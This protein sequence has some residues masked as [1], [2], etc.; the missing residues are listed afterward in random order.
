MPLSNKA[1]PAASTAPPSTTGTGC[2]GQSSRVTA[3]M[4]KAAT[5]LASRSTNPFATGSPVAATSNNTGVNRCSAVAG[6][7]SKCSASITWS[8][9]VAGERQWNENVRLAVIFKP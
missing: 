2:R 7:S 6:S 4:T 3:A 8:T 9:L 1:C 5:S